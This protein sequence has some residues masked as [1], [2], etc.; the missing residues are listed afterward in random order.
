MTFSATGLPPS[1]VSPEGLLAPLAAAAAP[2]AAATAACWISAADSC[3]W[4]A[5]AG[6]AAA[7][8]LIE[9][10]ASFAFSCKQPQIAQRQ[11]NRWIRP[12]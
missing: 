2:L 8:V 3:G 9:C 4:L 11:S 12:G 7:A 10:I 1:R 6:G 5:S